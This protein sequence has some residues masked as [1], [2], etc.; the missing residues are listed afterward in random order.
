MEKAVQRLQRKNRLGV[1]TWESLG[2]VLEN[3]GDGITSVGAW[4]P[5]RPA[6]LLGSSFQA[7]EAGRPQGIPG[8]HLCPPAW[9]AAQKQ[10]PVTLPGGIPG[11]PQGWTTLELRTHSSVPHPQ[12]LVPLHQMRRMNPPPPQTCCEGQVRAQM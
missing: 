2:S 6:R 12:L 1:G 3:G 9:A 8:P 7:W 11:Q 4:A 10:L 5:G